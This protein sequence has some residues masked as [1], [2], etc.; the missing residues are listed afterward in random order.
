MAIHKKILFISVYLMVL[1]TLTLNAQVVET[2]IQDTTR[3]KELDLEQVEVV[4]EFDARIGRVKMIEVQPSIETSETSIKTY[5]YNITAVPVDV[6]YPAPVIRPL[7][8]RPILSYESQSHW[9]RLGYSSLN[10]PYASLGSAIRYDELFGIDTYGHYNGGSATDPDRDYQHIDIDLGGFYNLDLF[11]IYADVDFDRKQSLLTNDTSFMI[12][13]SLD[14]DRVNYQ[15]GLSLGIRNI[16]EKEANLIYDL[17]AAWTLT[18]ADASIFSGSENDLRIGGRATYIFN[19]LNLVELKLLNHLTDYQ[20]ETDYLVDAELSSRFS[21]DQFAY[22]LGIN[23]AYINDSPAIWPKLKIE[24]FDIAKHYIQLSSDQQITKNSLN[25]LLSVNQFIDPNQDFYE[26]RIKQTI[27]LELKS[28]TDQILDYGVSASYDILSN[29][30]TFLNSQND[31][32]LFD[33]SYEDYHQI[34]LRFD[35]EYELGDLFIVNGQLIK[36]FFIL[37]DNQTLFH[38][39]SLHAMGSIGAYLLEEDRLHIGAS[40]TATEATQYQNTDLEVLKNNW[41]Y[42]LSIE[43]DYNFSD[44]F[45][46]FI[47]GNNLLNNQYSLLNGYPTFGIHVIGGI[48]VQF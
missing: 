42:D 28:N 24:L 7:A 3:S 15:N 16:N 23:V 39:P 34:A 12:D 17:Q 8:M 27:S 11:Q 43:A 21:R 36:Q 6:D 22:G 37:D 46:L 41:Q 44:H 33:I 20:N 18:N 30:A 1:T 5:E 10:S 13:P 32:R 31:L 14:F 45:G 40:F 25:E 38:I 4:K 29:Q 9:A 19:D 48:Q 47:K 35:C 2:E 26:N